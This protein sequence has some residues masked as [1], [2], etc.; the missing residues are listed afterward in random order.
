MGINF[1]LYYLIKEL[2]KVRTK[3]LKNDYLNNDWQV[4]QSWLLI[5]SRPVPGSRLWQAHAAMAEKHHLVSEYRPYS[6]TNFVAMLLNTIFTLKPSRST[7]LPSLHACWAGVRAT[8]PE[9]S[10]VLPNGPGLGPNPS[11]KEKPSCTRPWVTWSQ[12]NMLH[13][14]SVPSHMNVK[15]ND[16]CTTS[17]TNGVHCGRQVCFGKLQ[18]NYSCYF[19]K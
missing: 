17:I 10:T 11:M 14:T 15:T 5:D 8:V 2:H 7:C 6:V 18:C 1:K 12:P 3:P 19:V 13:N 9:P 16:E 4:R